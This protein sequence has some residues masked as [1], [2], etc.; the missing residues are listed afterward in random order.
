MHTSSHRGSRPVEM[1][2]PIIAHG[3]PEVRSLIAAAFGGFDELRGRSPRARGREFTE[4]DRCVAFERRRVP[5][6]RRQS[7]ESVVPVWLV[8]IEPEPSYKTE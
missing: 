6:D 7:L 3:R 8:E 5:L 1:C 2:E 4:H